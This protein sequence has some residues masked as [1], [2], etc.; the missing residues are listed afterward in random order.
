VNSA[1]HDFEANVVCWLAAS[2]K[3]GPHHAT[4]EVVVSCVGKMMI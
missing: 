1:R 2:P 4:Y 3:N